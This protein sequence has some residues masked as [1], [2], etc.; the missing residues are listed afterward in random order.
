MCVHIMPTTII[1]LFFIMYTYVYIHTINNNMINILTSLG[2]TTVFIARKFTALS[3]SITELFGRAITSLKYELF[4]ARLARMYIR[5][6]LADQSV[7]VG[8]MAHGNGL[9]CTIN[10]PRSKGSWWLPVLLYIHKLL[11]M[12]DA[13]HRKQA[14]SITL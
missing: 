4:S 12:L 13:C 11:A 14:Y 9:S 7:C 5:V 1:D 2:I 8:S 10:V 3:Y 6:Q